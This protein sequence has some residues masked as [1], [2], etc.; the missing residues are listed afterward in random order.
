MLASSSKIGVRGKGEG[1]GVFTTRRLGWLLRKQYGDPT[2]AL[3]DSGSSFHA[4]IVSIC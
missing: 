2:S 1:G 4:S 3:T